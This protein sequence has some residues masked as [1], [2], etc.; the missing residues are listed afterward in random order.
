MPN[1]PSTQPAP[2]KGRGRNQRDLDKGWDQDRGGRKGGCRHAHL[3]FHEKSRR[4]LWLS[5]GWG[6]SKTPW[7]EHRGP[8]GWGVSNKRVGTSGD[9]EMKHL[10]R[11][12]EPGYTGESP[13][14]PPPPMFALAGV[15][16][17][18]SVAKPL[19]GAASPGNPNYRPWR[20]GCDC[21]G[22]LSCAPSASPLSHCSAEGHHPEAPETLQPNY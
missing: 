14:P 15:L 7:E 17:D 3:P 6:C 9:G 13:P 2:R 21:G 18:S 1:T 5:R 19:I 12:L 4:P 10:R 8:E 20:D 16:G 11:W 22:E